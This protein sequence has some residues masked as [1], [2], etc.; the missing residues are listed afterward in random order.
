MKC[1]VYP[2]FRPSTA[3]SRLLPVNWHH[4]LSRDA[5]SCHVTVFPWKLQPC[6]KWNVQYIPVFSTLQPLPGDFLSN[7][8]TSGSLPSTWGHVTSFPLTWLPPPASYSLVGSEFCSIGLFSTLYSHFQVTSSQKT[9]LL[10][11]FR[12]PEVTWHFLSQDWLLLPLLVDFRSNDV[13]TGSLP[14]TLG[15]VTSIP[16][17]WRPPPASYS[18]V[19]TEM[20]SIC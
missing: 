12:L 8:I 11:H 17:M 2:G 15:H 14:V 5:I 10:G 4:F 6:R 1:T 19:G 16:I 3:T 9:S 18:L 7:D 13:T 20:F